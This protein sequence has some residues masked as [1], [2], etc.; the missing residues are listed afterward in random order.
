ME[1]TNEDRGILDYILCSDGSYWELLNLPGGG[2]R[3]PASYKTIENRMHYMKMRGN[4]VFKVAVRCMED[5][6]LK[7]LKRNNITPENIRFFIPHQANIRII[8][9]VAKRLKIPMEKVYITIHKYG[10][11]SAASIPVALDEANRKGVLKKGDI[12]LMSGF[13]GGCTWAAALVKW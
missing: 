3:Y 9:S 11:T 1:S 8:K 2:S 6:S 10:N 4:E 7:I 5:V 13:G 12:I